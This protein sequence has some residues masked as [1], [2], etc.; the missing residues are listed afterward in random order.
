[1]SAEDK[2]KLDGLSLSSSIKTIRIAHF[3]IGATPQKMGEYSYNPQT[4]KVTYSNPDIMSSEQ[5]DPMPDTLY[6]NDDEESDYPLGIYA[7]D[8]E[9]KLASITGFVMP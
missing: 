7:M 3:G 5:F 2:K 4:N 8:A 6:I 1:M 9:G